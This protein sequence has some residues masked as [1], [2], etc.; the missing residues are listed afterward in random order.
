[1][2]L[3]LKGLYTVSSHL[4]IPSDFSLDMTTDCRAQSQED[5]QFKDGL[6]NSF[7]SENNKQTNTK[8]KARKVAPGAVAHYV[9]WSPGVGEHHPQSPQGSCYAAPVY[10]FSWRQPT[11]LSKL[12]KL[13][14]DLEI[15]RFIWI[16]KQG[17]FRRRH[18]SDIPET[19]GNKYVDF[20][21]KVIPV[22]RHLNVQ[23]PRDLS[24]LG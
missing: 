11:E 1:M 5:L 24:I 6:D 8:R 23:R 19:S 14:G 22:R 10:C 18:L 4:E 13:F 2:T 21:N 20:R 17:L 15:C 7:C 12:S 3:N 16:D 9:R